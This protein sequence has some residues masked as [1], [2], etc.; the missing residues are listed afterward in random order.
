MLVADRSKY[1]Y[2]DRI[3][4]MPERKA[5]FRQVAK[6]FVGQIPFTCFNR[7]KREFVREY[8][9]DKKSF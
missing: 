9:S 1:D 3:E 4:A 2:V 6:Y 8:E 5:L 7:K